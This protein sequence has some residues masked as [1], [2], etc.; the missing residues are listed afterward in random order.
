MGAGALLLLASGAMAQ[1][2]FVG[3]YGD[4]SVVEIPTSG[5]QSTFAT[6]LGYP[7]ALAFNNAG[8]TL[9]V[10]NQFVGDILAYPVGGGSP[11]TFAQSLNNPMSLAFNS[12]GD[13]FVGTQDNTI[14]EYAP[15]GGTPTVFANASS[16]V[17]GPD[18]LAFNAAG[19][20]F[21]GNA[22]GDAGGAGYILEYGPG[23]GA[24]TLFAGNLTDPCG[25][26]F[27]ATGNLFVT[28]GALTDTIV[29]YGPNG[30]TPTTFATGLDNCAALAFNDAG[31][32]FVTDAGDG[33]S[34]NITELSPTG[35]TLDVITTVSQPISVAFQ[36]EV[37]P[38]PEPSTLGLLGVGMAVLLARR[39]K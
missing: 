39:R 4:N 8:T 38:V 11:T 18:A 12:A 9:Y 20:L 15:G 10:E 37:L 24:P 7:G 33:D 16:G 28:E 22:V 26:A 25:L 6:G 29:E 32:L 2:M 31:D 3:S 35:H 5:P 13:L 19:D 17:N 23:G 14:L 1:N 34:G 30:G 21:V 27:N 36:G